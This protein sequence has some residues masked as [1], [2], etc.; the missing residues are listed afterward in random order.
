MK[1]I[2]LKIGLFLLTF[3]SFLSV[4][5]YDFEVDGLYY[6]ITSLKGLTVSVDGCVNKDTTN[7]VI[8][9]T[10]EYKGKKLI[11][12]SVGAWAFSNLKNYNLYHS[13]QTY[14]QSVKVHFFMMNF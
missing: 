14:C 12:T 10:I 6:T 11:V 8:P 5:A 7:I 1:Q 13:H 2:S 9:Q 4:S 3:F